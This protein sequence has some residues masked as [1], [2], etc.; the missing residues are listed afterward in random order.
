MELHLVPVMELHLVP[1][2]ELHLVPVME[3]HLV[4]NMELFQQRDL[5]FDQAI[6]VKN[7][8]C[9]MK[10]SNACAVGGLSQ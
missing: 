4:P 5:S 6:A 2:M 9:I 3:L 8:W 1:V 7:A 10:G